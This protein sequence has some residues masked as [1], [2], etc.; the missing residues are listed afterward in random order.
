LARGAVLATAELAAAGR[1]CLQARVW[2]LPVTDPGGPSAVGDGP[3]DVAEQAQFHF[4]YADQLQWRPVHG[5]PHEPGP[6]SVWVSPRIPLCPGEA[7]TGLQRVALIADSASGVSAV[8]DWDSW[9]FA[10]VDLDLHLVRQ[11]RGDWLR[12]DAV[13]D[14]GS[15]SALTSSRLHDR[16]GPVGAG[17]QTLLVRRR[18]GG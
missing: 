13:T 1:S 4:P 18:D 14:L 3:D 11:V 9:S 6:A 17:L 15:G 8:L 2:L 10:N 16:G 7:L 12:M 5:S